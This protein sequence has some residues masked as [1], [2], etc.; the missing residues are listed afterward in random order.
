MNLSYLFLIAMF[1]VNSANAAQIVGRKA[2]AKYFQNDG[3][4]EESTPRSSSRKPSSNGGELLVLTIGGF[5]NSEAFQW[6]GSDKRN[7]I[8]DANYGVTYLYDQKGGLDVHIRLEF[9]EFKIDG[10]RPTKL[11]IMPLF[12]F[13]M[14]SSDFPLYFGFGAGAGVFFKQ[15]ENESNL[16]LDYQLV[17]GLR[18]KDLAPGFGISVEVGL[19]NHLHLLSDGQLNANA[20]SLGGVFSF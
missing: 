3:G 10:E 4:A 8:A 14:A 13:P 6:K 5:T 9:T 1:F 7:G 19:K 17:T 20:L 2:A 16:S 18:F 15:I 12:T 11:T